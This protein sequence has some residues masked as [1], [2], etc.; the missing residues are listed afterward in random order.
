MFGRKRS[1]KPA[2]KPPV[3][4]IAYREFHEPAPA[5][6][7][8]D[9]DR[10]YAYTWSLAKAP[11]LG[12][13]VVLEVSDGPRGIVVGFGTKYR[14]ALSAVHAL[15]TPRQLAAAAKRAEKGRS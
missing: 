12:D 8:S 3:V 6:D 11:E 7:P 13:R 1:T 4:R 9:L 15:A 10:G 2:P 5:W 14:G